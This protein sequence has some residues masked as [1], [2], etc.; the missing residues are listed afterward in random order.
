MIVVDASAVC[1][2][3]LHE[4]ERAEVLSVLELNVPKLIGA[5]NLWEAQVRLL[6][7]NPEQGPGRVTELLLVAKVE[8]ASIDGEGVS[9]AFDAFRRFGKGRG[10][11]LNLGDCFAYGLAKSLDAD[12]LYVG[13]DFDGTDVRRAMRPGG[14]AS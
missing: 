9:A 4:P 14:G 6:K 13:R 10:G 12:L 3:L 11:P 5:V 2:V 8:L 1:A 7:V